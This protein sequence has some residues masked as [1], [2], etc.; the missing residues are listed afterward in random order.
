LIDVA[1][2]YDILDDV[3]FERH[4]QIRKHI[5]EHVDRAADRRHR[6]LFAGRSCD[7]EFARRKQKRSG[8]RGVDADRDGSEAFLVVTAVGDEAGNH[9]EIIQGWISD[10]HQD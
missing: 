5:F 4:V 6:N 9:F 8:F 1:F 3:V 7:D 10:S 2:A